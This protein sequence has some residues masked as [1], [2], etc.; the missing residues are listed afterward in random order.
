MA[1]RDQREEC[2]D[3]EE[4]G[5][6]QLE[7]LQ[8][9]L[10]RAFKSIPFYRNRFRESSLD[11]SQVERLE[12][13]ATVPFTER[14]HF[15]EN[16]PY[17]LFAVPLRDVVRIHTSPGLFMQPTVSGYT[18]HDLAVWRELV[19]RALVAAGVSSVDILQVDL[20]VGLANW[21][22]DY[23]DGAE[24]VEASVIPLTVLHP[25]KQLM[26]LRDYRTST[27][28]TTAS[29]ASQLARGMYRASL[30]ANALALK[31]LI[32]VG[33]PPDDEARHRLEDEL[34]VK[35]WVHYGLSDVPGP[36][37]AFEC[38][39]RDGLHVSEDHFLAEVIDRDSGKPVP[40]G[41]AGELVLTTLTT[42][43]FPLVRFKTGDRVR[44]VHGN[45]PCGRT[46]RRIQW[47]PERAD[48]LMVIRGVKVN[49]GHAS[50]V[51]E[52][53]L[54]FVPA[55]LR[56]LIR[57]SPMRDYL[58]IWLQ[59]EDR[60]FSDEIKQMEK[61]VL[62]LGLEL[63]QELGVSVRIRFKEEGSF[64]PSPLEPVSECMD[65]KDGIIE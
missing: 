53:V 33:E 60:L 24:I 22:R 65:R 20:D 64:Q 8:S 51:M 3:L 56:F 49:R 13:L 62:R 43:A 4:R 10:N 41:E 23:K 46:L 25:E 42:R 32:L 21:G 54:G 36:A 29:A 35:T 40:E 15:S 59:V 55:K 7:R 26:I 5:Q 58:E 37:L 38:D 50:M 30:N 44:F 12:D 27:L 61:V 34:H 57:K 1:L 63:E 17:G 52:R 19:A 31:T 18:K 14:A 6:Q 28:V 2:L 39:V 16:Y 47:L 48:D 11:P 9:V 45:C